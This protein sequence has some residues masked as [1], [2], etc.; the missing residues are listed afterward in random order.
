MAY[1]EPM[2]PAELVS[3]RIDLDWSQGRMATA[4]GVHQTSVS[5][6]E[7]GRKP[8]PS[9]KAALIRGIHSEIK[10]MRAAQMRIAPDPAETFQPECAPTPLPVCTR[11]HDVCFYG[12]AFSFALVIVFVWFVYWA[13]SDLD[14]LVITLLLSALPS[15]CVSGC[16][17]WAFSTVDRGETM[18]L[19]SSSR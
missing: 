7:A 15:L 6:W 3:I 19:A 1:V 13:W 14:S 17:L 4:L 12:S 16:C 2:T 11:W 18:P 5:Q 9:K 10:A 8:I